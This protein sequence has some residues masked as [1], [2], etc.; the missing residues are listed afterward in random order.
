MADREKI[1][2]HINKIEQYSRQP[3]NQW[4]LAE[5]QIRF[6]SIEKIDAIYEY[7][8]ERVVRE[9]AV[10]Y[11]K[12]FPLKEIVPGLVDDFVRMEFFRRKNAFDDFSIA[13][14][15]QIER[16]TNSVAQ[17]HKLYESYDRLIG[18]PAYISSVLQ[19]DGTWVEATI[20]DRNTSSKYPIAYLVFGKE[21]A[22]KK[23]LSS[24][25]AQWAVDK[26][27]CVLYF[28]CY[29][30][31]LKNSEYV[32]FIEYKDYINAIYQFRN[33]NHRG[34]EPNEIQ[35]K[36]I[37]DIRP[38]QGVYYFKFMQT[39]LFYVEGVAKGLDELDTLYNYA[40][41]QTRRTV[42]IVAPTVV[43]KKELP[44]DT[45]KRF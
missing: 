8:I 16:I 12:K 28:M 39:L 13:V 37:D 33:L 2:E 1:I 41:T 20:S 23:S 44:T 27:I 25:P 40:M 6:G 29:Q 24:L 35:K 38:Q 18:H 11:Y 15:Q 26:A 5:L 30:A 9:Q 36:I 14:Y 34:S 32:Q 22:Y 21:Q 43:G 7:C 31:K 10:Q 3:G 19:A 4:L 17:N 42:Q 45:K